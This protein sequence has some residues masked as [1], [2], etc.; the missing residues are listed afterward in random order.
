MAITPITRHFGDGLVKLA[1]PYWGKPRIAA[2]LRAYLR[3]VQIIEDTVWDV[4]DRYTIAGADTARLDVLGRIVGQPRY[5]SDDEIYRSV[6]RGK[7]RANRSR[8]LTEDIVE[9]VRC[10][11]PA[12]ES[13]VRVYHFSPA[14]MLVVP[15]VEVS[16]AALEAL[17]FLLPA[18]RAAGVQMHV[19]FAPA[20][21]TGEYDFDST[22]I[23]FDDLTAPGTFGPGF[24]DARLL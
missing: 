4:L 12:T 9:V 21:V 16:A 22:G 5:W 7:I 8:G 23:L 24:F 20:A 2:L 11:P 3:Q 19:A 18:T 13:L 14:T 17:A 1:P 10:V 6:I 15:V